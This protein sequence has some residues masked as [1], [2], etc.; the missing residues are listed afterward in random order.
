MHRISLRYRLIALLVIFTLVAAYLGVE[1]NRV[2]KQRAALSVIEKSEG[3]PIYDY[4]FSRK[5][6]NGS[7]VAVRPYG[8]AWLHSLVGV[9]YF[10]TILGLKFLDSK[11]TDDDLIQ[12]SPLLSKLRIL[13]LTETS[14]SEKGLQQ[15]EQ[16]SDLEEI[17]LSGTSIGD[18]GLAWVSRCDQLR[19][20]LLPRTLITDSGLESLKALE[21]L[22]E[23]NLCCTSVTTDGVGELLKRHGDTLKILIVK[24]TLVDGNIL[25]YLQSAQSLEILSI[26]GIAISFEERQ[27]IHKILPCCTIYHE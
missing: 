4:E 5:V 19:K 26:E 14:V 9:D 1:S 20:V 25:P 12:L 8:P 15:L 2:V 24:H 13:N 6:R 3:H 27:R 10:R 11:V 21:N 17:N 7:I 23:I 18:D 22:E 16:F